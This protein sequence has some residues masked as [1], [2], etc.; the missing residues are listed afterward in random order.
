MYEEK[1]WAFV[2]NGRDTVYGYGTR[3]EAEEFLAMMAKDGDLCSAQIITDAEATDLG[4]WPDQPN[5]GLLLAGVLDED[6]GE[7][8]DDRYATMTAPSGRVIVVRD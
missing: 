6:V 1:W 7:D 8:A 4:L 5:T 3:Q 2:G